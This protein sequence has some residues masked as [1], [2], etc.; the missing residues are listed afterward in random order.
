MPQQVP[1]EVAVIDGCS[2][3]TVNPDHHHIRVDIRSK[4]LAVAKGV[5]LCPRCSRIHHHPTSARTSGKCR[6][7]TKASKLME[8]SPSVDPNHRSTLHRA[9]QNG[10]METRG[11]SIRH[12]KIGAHLQRASGTTLLKNSELQDGTAKL[13]S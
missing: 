4:P 13:G 7:C 10:N 1:S 11:A 2:A 8:K 5:P 12:G 6:R 9:D 3:K